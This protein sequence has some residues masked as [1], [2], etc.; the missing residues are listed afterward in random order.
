M[1]IGDDA[2]SAST[3]ADVRPITAA[4]ANSQIFF[5]AQHP[6]VK[7]YRRLS[8]KPPVIIVLMLIIHLKIV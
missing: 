2:S 7:V 4:E 5:I 3:A 8:L 6:L 1:G